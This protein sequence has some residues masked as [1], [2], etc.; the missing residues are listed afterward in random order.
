MIS[1]MLKKIESTMLKLVLSLTDK[2]RNGGA[3]ILFGPTAMIEIT[4]VEK[5]TGYYL[6]N[7]RLEDFAYKTS[8]EYCV[9]L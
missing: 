5:A 8:V 7:Q 1:F 4:E 3:P 6:I 9:C 2:Q